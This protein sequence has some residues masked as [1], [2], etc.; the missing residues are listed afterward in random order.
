MPLNENHTNKLS[1]TLKSYAHFPLVE[2]MLCLSVKVPMKAE[3][4]ETELEGPELLLPID[5]FWVLDLQPVN[6]HILLCF[7]ESHFATPAVL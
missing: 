4:S 5:R 1:H 2:S 3:F 7:K 6:Q